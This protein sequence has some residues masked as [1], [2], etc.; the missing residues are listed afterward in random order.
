MVDRTSGGCQFRRTALGILGERFVRGEIDRAEYEEKRK[1]IRARQGS[2]GPHSVA[3]RQLP[4]EKTEARCDGLPRCFP[5]DRIIGD[6][7]PLEQ[8]PCL[9]Q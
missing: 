5:R 1:S 7:L 4:S 8:V 6:Y 2:A 9:P 3:S